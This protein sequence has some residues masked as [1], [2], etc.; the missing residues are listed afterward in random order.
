MSFGCPHSPLAFRLPQS[1]SFPS[2]ASVDAFPQRA[3]WDSWRFPPPFLSFG[4]SHP[5]FASLYDQYHT[6]MGQ[7]KTFRNQLQSNCLW[8]G[9]RPPE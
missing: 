2:F 1:H 8:D 9:D 7:V 5:Q 6:C 4:Y 3:I